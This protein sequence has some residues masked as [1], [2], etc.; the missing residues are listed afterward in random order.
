MSALEK[1][2]ELEDAVKFA[3][4]RFGKKWEADAL[5]E[6]ATLRAKASLADDIAKHI[7]RNQGEINGMIGRQW[8]RN[9][10]A[11]K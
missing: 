7:A 10:E 4:E 9:Y 2:R 6:L 3:E 5:A 1:W 8:L 11:I